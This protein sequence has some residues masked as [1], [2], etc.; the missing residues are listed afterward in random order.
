[1]NLADKYCDHIGLWQKELSNWMPDKL[2]DAH[3]HI[4]RQEDLDNNFSAARLKNALSTYSAMPLEAMNYWHEHLYSG[5]EISGVFAFPF[6]LQEINYI[7]A[8][9]YIVE[10]MLADRRVK[11]FLWTDQTDIKLTIETF[12]NAE[13]KGVRFFGVKPYYDILGKSNF[14]T[15]M[16]E[17]LPR[18]LL[19]FINSEKLIMML[20]TTGSG[21]GEKHVRD[22]V[23]FIG[24]KFPN[25]KIVLA[26]MG[27]HLSVADFE[28]F[29]QSGLPEIP[30]VFLEM[31]SSSQPEIYMMVLEKAVLHKKLLFGS[32]IPFGLITGLEQWSETAGA[33]F[34]TRDKYTWSEAGSYGHAEMTYNTYHVLKALKDAMLRLNFSQEQNDKLK[35]KIFYLNARGL[36]TG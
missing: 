19:E 31:S 14:E 18:K 22:Y 29:M 34:R 15:R 2:F 26:H 28:A 10:A 4:G 3:V 8:N 33:I 30:S 32:D 21:I 25:I 9:E 5:R 11:G 36:I 12:S 35:Q 16:D 1:M 13:R 24:D 27:R 17:I 20:H 23:K 7:R 6:P